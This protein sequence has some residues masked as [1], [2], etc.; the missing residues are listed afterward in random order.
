[1]RFVIHYWEKDPRLMWINKGDVTGFAPEMT[2]SIPP[3]LP[4]WLEV[5]L[6]W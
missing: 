4:W 3:L 2:K 5:E 6:T 1:M